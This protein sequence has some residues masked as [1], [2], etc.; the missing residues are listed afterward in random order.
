MNLLIVNDER[1]TADLMKDDIDWKSYGIDQADAVYS[2]AS[3]RNKIRERQVDILLCDIE[4]PEENGISLLRWC[5]EEGYPIE[6]IFLTCHATFEYAQEALELGCQQYLVIPTKDEKIGEAVQKAANRVR[7]RQEELEAIDHWKTIQAKKKPSENTREES[8]NADAVVQDVNRD[9][10][11]QYGDPELSVNQLAERY[12]LHPV[13]LNRIF[14]RQQGD[15]INHY[16]ITVRMNAAAE[17]LR[18]SDLSTGEIAERVGYRT[19]SNFH[20][21][22][23]NAFGCTPGQYRENGQKDV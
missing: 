12:H 20:L 3:A 2:A 22:F 10:L 7:S 23:R 13:Y 18:S 8:P 15:S 6:C 9:I 21:T 17:L 5:R 16:I 4:M 19:Y 14:K 11:Q 1:L